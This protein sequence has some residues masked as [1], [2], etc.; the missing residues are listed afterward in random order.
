MGNIVK[1][2]LYTAAYQ[3]LIMIAPILTAP[4]LARVLG[5]DNLGIYG[6]I[7]SSGNIITTISLLGIY[8]YG[9]RQTA[10]VRENRYELNKTFWEL[11]IARVILG[12][13]GTVLYII[14]TAINREYSFFFLVYYPYILAQYVDCS[15]V[16]VGME[17][18]KPAVMKNFITKIV[19]IAGVFLFVKSREDLWIYFVLL[20]V[21]TLIANISIYTQL[22]QY[23]SK[24]KF[25]IKK[26][27]YHIKGSFVLFLPQVA[28]LF[29]LQVDKVMLK[30][31]T[32]AMDQVSFYEQA[33][34]IVTIPLSLITVVS[35]VMMPRLANEFKKN[36]RGNIQKLL[37]KAGRYTL[38]MAMPMMFG[39]ACVARKF[40]PW[41]L[42]TEFYPTAI[43]I[44]ILS[45]IVLFNSLTGISG[46]QYFTATDQ[47][48]ILLR[49]YTLAAIMNIIVN[50]VLIPRYG[51]R[52]AAIA[53]VFSS[54][55]SVI[56][57]FKYLNAQVDI[58]AFWK[59]G[60]DYFI[61]GFIMAVV[62]LSIGQNLNASAKTTFFQVTTGVGIF[63]LY[64]LLRK[65]RVLV[66]CYQLAKR[67]L[68]R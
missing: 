4:Y 64:L 5:A 13:L 19:N 22:P 56:V 45:P 28:S 49:A 39:I 18:M 67:K 15:W 44:I 3:I 47:I 68:N 46:K 1:N 8:A 25:E 36:N 32:G 52:G 48:S 14:Y 31:L 54:L 35:T 9:N 58:K 63:L 51:Y 17:N 23:I 61:G 2:Y 11:A 57:Q 59:W 7:N 16:F 12:V 43:A 20:S 66:E 26:L 21:T 50:A 29:Y 41:Y 65:D 30:W 60:V 27:T 10:Y 62:I 55:A 33:E 6:Y 24:P 42:G 37:L 53:T 34:K 40:I 38:C